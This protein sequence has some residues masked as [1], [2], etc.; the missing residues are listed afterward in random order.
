M[1]VTG[2]F[3]SIKVRLICSYLLLTVLTLSLVGGFTFPFIDYFMGKHEREDLLTNAQSLAAQATTL[4]TPDIQLGQLTDLVASFSFLADVRVRIS[5]A[6]QHVII[7]TGQ[8]QSVTEA[9]WALLVPGIN[10][11]VSPTPLWTSESGDAAVSPNDSGATVSRSF[12]HITKT[13]VSM[14][15]RFQI[16]PDRDI[17]SSAGGKENRTIPSPLPERSPL[18]LDQ[19]RRLQ[20]NGHST[21][22]LI[23]V[24]LED[25]SRSVIGYLEL[26]HGRK[27]YETAFH[28]ALWTFIA[29]ACVAL[30]VAAVLGIIAGIRISTPIRRLN[31]AAMLMGDGDLTVRTD[32]SDPDEIGQLARQFD[33]MAFRLQENFQALDREK[34]TLKRF[35]ADASHELRSP[36]SAL[37]NSIEILQSDKLNDVLMKKHFLL[38]SERQIERL[39]WI[40]RNLLDLSRLDSDFVEMVNEEI[41]CSELFEAIASMYQEAMQGKGLILKMNSTNTTQY[42]R[43]DRGRMLTALSNL[44]DNAIKFTASGGVIELGAYLDLADK[45]MVLSVKDSGIGISD[46]DL[47]NI[48]ERFYRGKS[49]NTEGSGLGLAIV[50]RVVTLHGGSITVESHLQHGSRFLIRLP[51]DKLS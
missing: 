24:V 8:E 38:Q 40:T 19:N 22:Q 2:L 36:L 23:A 13:Q 49:G 47:P 31:A 14:G 26:S 51:F 25:S 5:D 48:F 15:S 3:R 32:I 7:D 21:G 41:P 30:A 27:P 6:D 4:L 45:S 28:T 16:E 20:G 42:V 33:R 17:A 34:A 50:K 35:I 43:C 39:E 18:P 12:W 1:M 9:I 46:E 10:P 44:M 37:S 29:V 11:V